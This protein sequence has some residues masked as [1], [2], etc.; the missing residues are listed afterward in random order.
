[1]TETNEL[2]EAERGPGVRARGVAGAGLLYKVTFKNQLINSRI[3]N[4]YLYRQLVC[5]ITEHISNP[6]LKPCLFP[7]H[8]HC[9]GHIDN[10]AE[11]IELNR[12]PRSFTS[13]KRISN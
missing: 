7:V 11:H 6:S 1:M 8:R 12:S 4:T 13:I 3:M 5:H 9:A 2:D 10:V